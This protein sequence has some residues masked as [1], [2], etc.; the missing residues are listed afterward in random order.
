MSINSELKYLY[1]LKKSGI[2]S[3]L[4]NTPIYR[5]NTTSPKKFKESSAKKKLDEIDNIDELKLYFNNYDK[6]LLK[7]NAHNTVF[8]DGNPNS[9]IML[10]GEAPGA[11]EDKKGLPFVGAAGELLNKMLLSINLK[12]NSVYIT[13]VVPWRPPNNRTP[14]DKEILECMPLVQKH[15][16]IIKPTIIILLGGTAS[17]AILATTLGISKIRG[18][19]HNYNSPNLK[20]KIIVR[21]IYHPAF[22]LRS[23]SYKKEVWIDLKEIQKK[24]EY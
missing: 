22:L 2:D 9:T 5:F 17:K 10:I 8:A 13:N 3:F 15:I 19:W 7:K 11:E 21:A 14:S 18:K 16:E 6:C 20:E 24:I 1:F 4:Q 12:R 23:P